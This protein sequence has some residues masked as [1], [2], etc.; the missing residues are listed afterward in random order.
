MAEQV[1]PPRRAPASRR[2][3]TPASTTGPSP[4][5]RASRAT[6]STREAASASAQQGKQVASRAAGGTRRV[7]RT[8]KSQTQDV[9]RAAKTQTQEVARTAT[10][11]AREVTGAVRAQVAQVGEE[12]ANQGRALVE[13]ARTRLQD[14]AHVQVRRA[15]DGLAKVARKARALGDEPDEDSS[16]IGSYLAQGADKLSQAADRI[17]GFADDVESGDLEIMVDD[18]K[19][20]ARRRPA[21]FAVGAAVAGFSIGRFVRAAASDEDEAGDEMDEME[22]SEMEMSEMDEMDDVADDA[23]L[24]DEAL[25]VPTRRRALPAGAGGRSR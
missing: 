1:S 23:E 6:A 19:T 8:A 25:A 9:T 24:L 18:L 4:R 3:R 5:A 7:A 16:G 15:A 10:E 20:F 14:Q 2:P 12:L 13:E 21:A 22:M 11:E 17:Y